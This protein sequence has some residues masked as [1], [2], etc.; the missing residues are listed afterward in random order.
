MENS[1]YRPFW[2]G[3]LEDRIA[4]LQEVLASPADGDRDDTSLRLA[5]RVL[6]QLRAELSSQLVIAS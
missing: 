5:L 6:E 3:P 1:T 4:R 2:D